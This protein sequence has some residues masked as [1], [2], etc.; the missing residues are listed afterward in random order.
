MQ[1]IVQRFNLI[2]S[3]D[4]L[5]LEMLHHFRGGFLSFK[6]NFMV[7]YRKKF[8]E[9]YNID[10]DSDFVVHHIDGNIQNNDISNLMLLPLS[11]HGK[12]HQ[13]LRDLALFTSPT[14]PN[15]DYGN[16]DFRKI[17]EIS[18]TNESS[19]TMNLFYDFLKV[20]S[21][22]QKWYDYK[23]YLDGKIPNVH[24]IYLVSPKESSFDC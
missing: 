7:N 8:K 14:F 3:T 6:E 18:G 4:K 5:T 20:L 19:F 22:C 15:V 17:F 24:G 13:K 16:K 9:H 23:L 11:L 12:Y 10:F 2:S 1:N 21:E